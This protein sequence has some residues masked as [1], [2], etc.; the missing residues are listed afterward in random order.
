MPNV[1][2]NGFVMA[3]SGFCFTD[4]EKGML[5]AI[6]S[7]LSVQQ[8]GSSKKDGFGIGEWRISNSEIGDIITT[9]DKDYLLEERKKE[10]TGDVQK[11]IDD[12]EDWVVKNRVWEYI[13]LDKLVK[14]VKG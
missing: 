2:F 1:V 7:A 10:F 5:L 4:I 13:P 14:K 9:A 11:Y 8:I 3:K 6:L 12:F